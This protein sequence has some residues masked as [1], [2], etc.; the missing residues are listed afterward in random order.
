MIIGAATYLLGAPIAHA[1]HGNDRRGGGSLAGRLLIPFVGAAA[2]FAIGNDSA[3][4]YSRIS[5]A[6]YG[7]GGGMVVTALIDIA[8]PAIDERGDDATVVVLPVRG[9]FTVGLGGSF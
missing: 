1:N 2:G 3:E 6:A 5:G 8:V 4:E 7:F 9:G